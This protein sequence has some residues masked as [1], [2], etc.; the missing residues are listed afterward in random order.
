MIAGHS[1]I[2]KTSGGHQRRENELYKCTAV[3]AS[4]VKRMTPQY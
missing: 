2:L 1:M 4:N 3:G